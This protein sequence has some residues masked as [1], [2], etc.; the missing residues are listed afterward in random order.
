MLP[1]GFFYGNMSKEREHGVIISLSR[2]SA[3]TDGKLVFTPERVF[4]ER[5]TLDS[6][7]GYCGTSYG[8]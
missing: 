3:R 7:Y 5:R 6:K 8:V 2:T 1:K 4:S